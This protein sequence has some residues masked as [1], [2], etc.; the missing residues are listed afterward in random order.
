M[1]KRLGP[2]TEPWGS[3]YEMG[4]MR[5]HTLPFEI[6]S[7]CSIS[8]THL[9]LCQFLAPDSNFLKGSEL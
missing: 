5:C 6:C 8:M 2:S 9:D 4:Y 1:E 7:M 3:P